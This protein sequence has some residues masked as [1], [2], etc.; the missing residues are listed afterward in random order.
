MFVRWCI[1]DNCFG[2]AAIG[3]LVLP[4]LHCHGGDGC[5]RLDAF[6]RNFCQLLNEGENR[7]ELAT[8]ILD[9]TLGDRD[10]GK[11]GD[12]TDGVGIDGHRPLPYRDARAVLIA[13]GLSIANS[14]DQFTGLFKG[15]CR[16]RCPPKRCFLRGCG[17]QE[18]PH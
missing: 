3:H 7:V 11:M 10:A 2:N 4:R 14:N 18:L 6:N 1:G 13:E 12:A 17:S 9:F 8:K 16:K 15:V 5:H